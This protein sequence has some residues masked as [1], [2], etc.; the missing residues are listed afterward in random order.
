MSSST[1]QPDLSQQLIEAN[2]D[3]DEFTR[4]SFNEVDDNSSSNSS[5]QLDPGQSM[6]KSNFGN[7]VDGNDEGIASSSESSGDEYEPLGNVITFENANSP[8]TRGLIGIRK[9]NPRY[10][11]ADVASIITP[12]K[13]SAKS[14]LHDKGWKGAMQAECDAMMR[15]KTWGLVPRNAD[16]N[17]INSLRLY[18]VKEKVDGSIDRLKASLVANGMK[19]LEGRNY[20]YTF[21]P[22]VKHLTIRL[23]LIVAV[24]RK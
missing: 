3:I 10:A 20:H 22:V 24:S 11:L 4:N 12:P 9:Q 14:A 5:D 7:P 17:V 23:V 2:S 1:N 19:Q 21:T 18:K 15:N 16:D 6:T 8:V 13:S